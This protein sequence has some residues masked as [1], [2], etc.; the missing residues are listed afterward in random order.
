M[1]IIINL[2]AHRGAALWPVSLGVDRE[3]SS[4]IKELAAGKKI[5]SGTCS[6]LESVNSDFVVRVTHH[7]WVEVLL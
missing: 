6:C 1:L 5:H 4:S 3:Q 7:I 2:C